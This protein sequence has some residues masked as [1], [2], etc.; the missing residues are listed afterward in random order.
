MKAPFLL[1]HKEVWGDRAD[2]KRNG[3]DG[4]DN[5]PDPG[6]FTNKVHIHELIRMIPSPKGEG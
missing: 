6:M 2:D 3:C 5:F 4:D 1:T